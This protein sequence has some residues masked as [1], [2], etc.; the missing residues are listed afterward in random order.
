MLSEVATIP[1]NTQR[2]A[3]NAA[4]DA[5]VA[6]DRAGGVEFTRRTAG[7]PFGRPQRVPEAGN[8]EVAL[9][10]AGRLAMVWDGGRRTL[11][12]FNGRA[13]AIGGS[14][15]SL[16][17][18]GF[19]LDNSGKATVLWSDCDQFRYADIAPDGTVATPQTLPVPARGAPAVAAAPDGTL[20]VMWTEGALLQV[21]V[22]PPGGAFEISQLPVGPP[23]N[24]LY[25]AAG[26]GGGAALTWGDSRGGL[27]AAVRPPGG[28]LGAPV[29]IAPTGTMHD[30][31]I[32][33]AGV[34]TAIHADTRSLW[35]TT[36]GGRTERIAGDEVCRVHAAVDTAGAL[37]VAGDTECGGGAIWGTV[38]PPGESF[39]GKV[40]AL[41][42][43]ANNH[44]P[45]L[46]ASGAGAIVAWPIGTSPPR[47]KHVM[48]A[49][50]FRGTPLIAFA[51]RP[52][53]RDGRLRVRLKTS[54]AVQVRMR[55]IVG[56]RTV[57]TV[58]RRVSGTRTFTVRRPRGA[59][60]ARV[61]LT[62]RGGDE[63]T[64][65]VRLT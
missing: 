10:D 37:Y 19:A 24:P 16:S 3:G 47:P 33:D 52:R 54:V 30:I 49:V 44:P 8:P 27:F 38:R 46:V 35:A 6:W 1:Q 14:G 39:P 20:V 50:A 58:Q 56:R 29:A 62:V 59:R 28:T 65:R 22:R 55:V 41:G 13:F 5:V 15:C 53:V 9:N 4:G 21:A 2:V 26:R 11:R 36:I 7:G 43:E 57:T 48:T 40:T 17:I 23:P 51:S 25:L 60:S 31:A 45:S 63:I 32:D 61:V 12:G 34:A 42:P 18:S 64:R